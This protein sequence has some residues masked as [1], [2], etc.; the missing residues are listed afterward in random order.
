MRAKFG[1]SA[2]DAVRRLIREKWD[3][4]WASLRQERA[5]H[6]RFAP[7]EEDSPWQYTLE[8]L[9]SGVEVTA[10]S[11]TGLPVSRIVKIER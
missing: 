6:E 5:A 9:D 7:R 3:K 1:E 10:Y 11:V 2:M 4:N 8:E